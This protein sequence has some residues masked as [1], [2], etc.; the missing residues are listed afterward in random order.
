MLFHQVG[1][2]ARAALIACLLCVVGATVSAQSWPNKPLKLIVPYAPAGG[3]DVLARNLAQKLTEALGQPV[4]VENRAGADG[5]IGSEFAARAPADGYT[6]LIASSSHAINPTLYAK[7]NFNTVKDFSC[8]TQTA[9]QQVILVVHPSL[10]VNN[11]RELIQYAKANPGTLNFASPSK[12]T[13]LPM[14]LF[15]TMA[16]IKM[17]NVPY[18]GSA[19]ALTDM[20]AGRIQA[21]F[22]GGASVAPHIKTGRLRALA[23]GDDRRSSF[24]PDLPTV[25]ESGLP[26]FHSVVWTGM[27]VPSATPRAIVNRLNEEVVRIMTSPDFKSKLEGQGFEPVASAPERCDGF[28]ATEI[29]TWAKVA[30]DAGIQPE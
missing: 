9:K 29:T 20:L 26:D 19:P 15:N 4:V 21:G 8:I 13:Q 17:T 25:A 16:G 5:M 14:E 2:P 28:I 30:K 22:G 24:M 23:V 6:M 7:I 18:K 11:V 10:P 1:S 27:F 3:T 12:A